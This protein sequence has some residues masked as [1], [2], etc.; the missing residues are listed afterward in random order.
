MAVRRSPSPDP[1]PASGGEGAYGPAIPSPRASG[2]GRE[3]PA[4]SGMVRGRAAGAFG[5]K[6]TAWMRLI[7]AAYL[8]PYLSRTGYRGL[9]RSLVGNVSN[10]MPGPS[11]SP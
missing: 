2:G 9:E 1:L 8:A 5:M 4:L 3:G 7:S 10:S 6:L 11:S